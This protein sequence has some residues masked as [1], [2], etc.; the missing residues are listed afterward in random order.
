MRASLSDKQTRLSELEAVLNVE[1]GAANYRSLTDTENG[2]L[3][4]LSAECKGLR[5]QIG[6]LENVSAEMVAN[7]S[8]LATQVVTGGE[9]VNTGLGETQKRV[10]QQFSVLRAIKSA[11]EDTKLTGVEAEMHQEAVTE[12][13]NAGAPY[14]PQARGSFMM[15]SFLLN[16]RA[17]T[18]TGSSGAEGG[19][20]VATNLGASV[21][22]LDTSLVLPSLGA[23]YM[24]G[25]VGNYDFP[26]ESDNFR[27]TWLAENGAA[28]NIDLTYGKKSLTPKRLAGV[29]RESQQLLLQTSADFEARTRA[30]ILNGTAL[31]IQNGAINGTGSSNQPTGLLT[32]SNT[33][34]VVGGTNGAAIT[35]DHLIAL[36][37][38]PGAANYSGG[39]FK[40]LANFPTRGKL[41]TTKTD[42]GSGLFLWDGLTSSLLGYGV[43]VTTDM[44]SN[45][46]KGSASGTCSAIAFGDFSQL[47]IGQWGGINVI[48]DATSIREQGLIRLIVETYADTLVLEPKAFSIM[49]DALTA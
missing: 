42:A 32:A 1:E 4:K 20:N 45:L 5:S 13:R 28:S 29:L 39:N 15:P 46:T 31:A 27:P 47:K 18:A 9:V 35:R 33:I 21:P 14:S 25:L 38:G 2:E 44:P 49:K 12:L 16:M 3:E 48:V 22:S 41:M 17:L 6:L 24:M 26:T 7:R 10:V 19:Y 43:G 8:V 37:N 36:M 11:A 23:D 30:K 34:A 40:W